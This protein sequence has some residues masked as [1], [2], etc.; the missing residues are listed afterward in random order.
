MYIIKKG[1]EGITIED[2]LENVDNIIMVDDENM[3]ISEKQ[4]E[5]EL[6]NK[7]FIRNKE[8]QTSDSENFEYTEGDA[9]ESQKQ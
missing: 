6:Q 1:T 9:S 5:E 7:I 2:Q 3:T 8:N 4:D